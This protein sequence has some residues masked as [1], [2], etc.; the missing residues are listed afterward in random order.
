M[1]SGK[2]K[3]KSGDNVIVLTGKDKGKAGEV[4]SVDRKNNRA[5]V[6]GVNIV[7]KHTK[8]SAQNPQG[9]IKEFESS[10]HI[11]N[12]AIL[13]QDNNP[14][15]VGYRIENNKKVRFIK[16]TNKTLS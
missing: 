4:I 14:S 1:H 6:K 10:I 8:P 3:I 15:K 11:S 12:I 7:K 9:G 16:S 5:V 2:T 13:D